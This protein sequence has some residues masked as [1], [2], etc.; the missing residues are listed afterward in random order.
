MQYFENSRFKFRQRNSRICIKG[1][2]EARESKAF[3]LGTGCVDEAIGIDKEPV[4]GSHGNGELSVMGIR[5][6]RQGQVEWKAITLA[7]ATGRS[8]IGPGPVARSPVQDRRMSGISDSRFALLTVVRD[9]CR[10]SHRIQAS[11][12]DALVNIAQN[13]PTVRRSHVRF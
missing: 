10:G 8:G 2:F 1:I 4:S 5:I 3:T 6:D 7:F 12:A 9:N 13:D 11:T